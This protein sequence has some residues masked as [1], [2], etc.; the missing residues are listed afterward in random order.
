LT[1]ANTADKPLVVDD[2][3]GLHCVDLAAALRQQARGT[4]LL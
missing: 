1:S 2:R 4:V 3:A